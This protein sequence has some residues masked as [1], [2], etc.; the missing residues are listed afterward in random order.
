MIR[1]TLT[2][3]VLLWY[4]KRKY[5][6]LPLVIGAIALASVTLPEGWFERMETIAHHEQ[7]QSAQSR[8]DAWRVGWLN[9]KTFPLT[10]VGLDGYHYSLV[11][12]DWHNSYVEVLAEHGFIGFGLW[13]LLVFG[14]MATL[15]GLAW[16]A[17]RVP[18]LRW[19]RSYSQMLV[20]SLMAYAAGSMFLGIS[21][22]DI[23]YQLIAVSVVLGALARAAARG[24]AVTG[25]ARS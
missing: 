3:L 19:V 12:K 13:A 21:Y 18:A 14:T 22:W 10:G 16:R 2:T 23:L 24:H 8:L 5:L 1:V 7:D 6:M 25:L 4:S 20:A 17:R 15:V 9:A 11:T